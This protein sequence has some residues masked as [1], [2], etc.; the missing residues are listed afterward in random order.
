MSVR[1]LRSVM[2]ERSTEL[3]AG[4]AF[5]GGMYPRASHLTEVRVCIGEGSGMSSGRPIQGMGMGS[6]N[7]G[8]GFSGNGVSYGETH[9]RLGGGLR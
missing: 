8:S 4:A 2:N 6:F 9:P 1:N 5:S 3:Y 7:A